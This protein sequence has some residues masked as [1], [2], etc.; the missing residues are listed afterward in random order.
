ML[1]PEL[2]IAKAYLLHRVCHHGSGFKNFLVHVLVSRQRSC[3]A[4]VQCPSLKVH[5]IGPYLG[6]VELHSHLFM[7]TTALDSKML[8]STPFRENLPIGVVQATGFCCK[9]S[10]QPPMG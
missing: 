5:E 10:L 8:N 6:L 7:E 2:A 9:L 1:S 4:L 3:N